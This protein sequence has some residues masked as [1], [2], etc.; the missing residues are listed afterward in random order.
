MAST[1]S[2]TWAGTSVP[3][4]DE[5]TGN[6]PRARGRMGRDAGLPKPPHAGGHHTNETPRRVAQRD[7]VGPV[8]ASDQIH[9][10]L[11]EA[12]GAERTRRYFGPDSANIEIDRD[13]GL[14]VLVPTTFLADALGRRFGTELASLAERL[15]QTDTVRFEVDASAFG[16]THRAEP[17][18][19]VSVAHAQTMGTKGR[20]KDASKLAAALDTFVVGRSNKLAFAAANRLAEQ[21]GASGFSPLV[22]HGPCGVGKTHLLRGCAAKAKRTSPGVRTKYVTGEAF[23]NGFVS[24]MK[25][26]KLDEFREVYRRLDLLCI[27]DVQ[28]FGRKGH[29]QQELLHTLDAI[30]LDGAGVVLA[31]DEHPRSLSDV[32]ENLRSRFMS[33]AIVELPPPD[34][35]LQ[36]ELVRSFSLR[37]GLVMTDDAIEL[38]SERAAKLGVAAGSASVRDLEGLLAQLD[39]VRKLV[40]DLC[41]TDGAI[42]LVLVRRALGIDSERASSQAIQRPVTLPQIEREVCRRLGISREELLGRGRHRRV[43]LGR[44]LLTTLSR[45]MTTHSYPEIGRSLG[46]V[47]HSTVVTAHKRFE[48]EAKEGKLVEVGTAD[49]GLTYGELVERIEGDLSRAARAG[50]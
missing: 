43:V 26:Q 23:T 3:A 28:F 42:G 38:V 37:R 29:T 2:N 8:N 47:N 15:T 49:D 22:I 30:G 41:A 18:P 25:T 10:A 39:A 19:P 32:T 31:S 11:L 17:P 21:R 36:R 24:A 6:T 12:L 7:R 45:R 33:G 48:R 35:D 1:S 14:R 16:D 13:A 50:S 34:R 44:A 40:P 5:K 9:E 46:R 27:D 4:R 20:G